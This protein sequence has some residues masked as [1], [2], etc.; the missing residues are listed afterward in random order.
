MTSTERHEARYQ[1][2][3]AAREKKR[4]ER[5]DLYDDFDRV[6]NPAA[7]MC[8]H[9]D[10]RRGVLWKYSPARYNKDYM[11]CSAGSSE[12]LY[13]GK[14]VC[15]GFYSF[16][17]V[18]RGKPRSIHSVHYTERVI[19][20]S[21]CVNAL[22]PIFSHNLIYDN[23]ASLKGKG[24]T[25]AASRCETHLHEYFREYGDNEGY[26]ILVDFT[27]FFDNIRYDCLFQQIDRLVFDK[28]LN[29]LCRQFVLA[30][31]MDKPEERKGLGLY[32]G[33]EDSQ[34]FAVSYP[35]PVDHFV[36]DGLRIKYYARYMDD[37]YI[38]CRDKDEARRILGLLF[39]QYQRLGIIP[40]KKKTQIVKLSRGFTFLKTRYFL[41]RSGRVVKK[42]CRESVVRQR[43]KLKKFRR[44]MDKGEM[45]I[46]QVCQSYMSWRGFIARKRAG[47]TIRSMD[48]LFY[49]M[50]H[51]KPWKT[52][53]RFTG[54]TYY[55]Q[56]ERYHPG[57]N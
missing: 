54:G 57:R 5:L 39:E 46:G 48:N 14:K 53:V 25:F 27:K 1:R 33:P 4:R 6:A 2:R 11:K 40:N 29:S 34:I 19:R 32:I 45:T 16:S 52:K 35:N 17:I 31:D 12:R 38:I 56:Q 3:K 8:A 43:R 9:F 47:R 28:R 26:I 44:F 37:A 41:E 23:G 49:S 51:V 22:V 13:A 30:G 55:E 10:A 42:P 50:F 21:A 18:E 24:I 36:K 7:L 15:Q 20:R